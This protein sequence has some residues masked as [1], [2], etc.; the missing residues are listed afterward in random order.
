VAKGLPKNKDLIRPWHDVDV[1]DEMFDEI[2]GRMANGESLAR[3]CR[4]TEKAYPSPA[5]F[6]KWVSDN[7][8]YQKRYARAMEIRSDVNVEVMLDIAE[9]ETNAVKARN[10][11]DVRK[12]H[13]EKLS[14]KKYGA[15]VLQESNVN[16]RQ[17]IDFSVMPAHVRQQLREALMRQ[18]Q[19]T[20]IEAD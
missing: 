20:L 15:K 3:I 6:L 17:K 1:K 18:I 12:Y 19:P 11:I 5:A 7:P 2:V 16:I 4:D 9:N 8:F 10:M 14:P 13:N